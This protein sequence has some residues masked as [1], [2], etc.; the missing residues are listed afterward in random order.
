MKTR[1]RE[2]KTILL[3]DGVGCF[4]ERFEDFEFTL[5]QVSDLDFTI[6]NEIFRVNSIIRIN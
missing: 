6:M 4:Y 5:T 3:C 1:R 2:D